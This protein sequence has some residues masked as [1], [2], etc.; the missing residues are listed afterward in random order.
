[1]MLKLII[2]RFLEKIL[3]L[4]DK[5]LHFMACFIITLVLG[6]NCA[7]VAALTKEFADWMYKR[8]CNVG[9]GWDWMDMAANAAGIV[10]GCVLRRIVFNY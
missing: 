8:N 2:M 5:V 9:N 3:K 10:L 7:A 1:M 6:E 4:N